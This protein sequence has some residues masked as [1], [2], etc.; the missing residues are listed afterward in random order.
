MKE[1]IKNY[2]EEQC[3]VDTYLADKYKDNLPA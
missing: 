2:L 3:K 1:I